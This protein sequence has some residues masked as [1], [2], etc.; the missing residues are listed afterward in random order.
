MALSARMLDTC[1]LSIFPMIDVGENV[2]P[3]MDNLSQMRHNCR[4]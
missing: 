2:L 4:A 3:G 1:L